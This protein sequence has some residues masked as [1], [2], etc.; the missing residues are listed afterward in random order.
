M[1]NFL[2]PFFKGASVKKYGDLEELKVRIGNQ[3]QNWQG[4]LTQIRNSSLDLT[5]SDFDLIEAEKMGLKMSEE[6]VLFRDRKSK[7]EIE[8]Q[9]FSPP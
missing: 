1:E 8:T 5:E 7:I 9:M 2:H 3:D 6:K 4:F